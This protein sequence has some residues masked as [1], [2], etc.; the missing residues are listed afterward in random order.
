ME[1]TYVN[2]DAMV[3]EWPQGISQEAIQCS[4]KYEVGDI[5]DTFLMSAMRDIWSFIIPSRR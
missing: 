2:L 4:L 1:S 5:L 3:Q